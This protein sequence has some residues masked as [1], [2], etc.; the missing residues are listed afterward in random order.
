MGFIDN[1]TAGAINIVPASNTTSIKNST[2]QKIATA[3]VATS[4]R[5]I[6]CHGK[7]R[8]EAAMPKLVTSHLRLV[9]KIAKSYRGYAASRLGTESIEDPMWETFG[10]SICVLAGL[11]TRLDLIDGRWRAAR[12][13]ANFAGAVFRGAVGAR[14]VL[15]RSGD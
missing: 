7:M 9:A 13:G 10:Y 3:L 15:R 2:C 11:G 14:S 6:N 1:E 12:V 5:L 4:R 8:A